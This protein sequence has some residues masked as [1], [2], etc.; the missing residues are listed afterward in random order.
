MGTVVMHDHVTS[1]LPTLQVNG[2]VHSKPG[3]DV[4]VLRPMPLA[5]PG[6]EAQVR[7][8]EAV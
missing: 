4:G 7:I 2:S 1:D 3:L 6:Y 8:G 5:V